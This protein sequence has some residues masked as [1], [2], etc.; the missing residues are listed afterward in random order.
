MQPT[1]IVKPGWIQEKKWNIW[2]LAEYKSVSLCLCEAPEGVRKV[3]RWWHGGAVMCEFVSVLRHFLRAL[4]TFFQLKKF[5]LCI[6]WGRKTCPLS[7][8]DSDLGASN[9]TRD[10]WTQ[11]KTG[12]RIGGILPGEAGKQVTFRR[13][14]GPL[15]QKGVGWFCD[16]VCLGVVLTSSLGGKLVF[17]GCSW[18]GI[19]VF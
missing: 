16:H 11:E 7:S 18:E 13:D 17:P 8:L 15:A 3:A 14:G 5:C 4:L 6:C 1:E 10:R 9:L 12:F 2:E 19:F